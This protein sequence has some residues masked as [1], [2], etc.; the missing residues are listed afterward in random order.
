MERGAKPMPIGTPISNDT[1]NG[2]GASAAAAASAASAAPPPRARAPNPAPSSR[3]GAAPA[4]W[5]SLGDERLRGGRA[6]RGRARGGRRRLGG[7]G[8]HGEAV[9][10]RDEPAHAS[11]APAAP[12]PP[13]ATASAEPPLLRAARRA[14]GAERWRSAPTP[15]G[16]LSDV[17]IPADYRPSIM[18]ERGGSIHSRIRPSIPF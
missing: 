16:A 14:S 2:A 4:G 7:R 5:S 1:R 17:S 13:S 8:R 3:G 10:R 6:A 11:A 18:P 9:A 12:R 15:P